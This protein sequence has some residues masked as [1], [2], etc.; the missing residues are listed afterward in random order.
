MSQYV[1][2]RTKTFTAAEAITANTLVKLD[3]AGVVS[4]ADST[5]YPIGVSTQACASGDAIAITLLNCTGT[6]KMVADGVIAIGTIVY[7]T[8]DGKVNDTDPGSCIVCG[9]TLEAATANN[10][11]IEV[12][13][14]L[15]QA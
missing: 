13:P 10:D 11:V 2:T 6:V 14:F 3:S 4:I 1:E 7:C 12:I 9:R 8:D 15:A 5:T